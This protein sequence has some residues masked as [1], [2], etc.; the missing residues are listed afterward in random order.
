VNDFSSKLDLP[1]TLKTVESI[2]ANH[3]Q[4]AKCGSKEDASYR[5]ISGVLRQF[6]RKEALTKQNDMLL[7]MPPAVVVKAKTVNETIE[8]ASG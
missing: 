6:I 8:G 7:V 5:A 3:I 4:M 1:R 2:D